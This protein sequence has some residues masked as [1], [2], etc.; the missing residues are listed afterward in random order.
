MN[1]V[2]NVQRWRIRKMGVEFYVDIHVWVNGEMTVSDDHG[3]ALAVKDAVRAS[4]PAVA[5]VLVHVE[6][7]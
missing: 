7:H 3:I 4:N 1:G 6:P 5:D 2:D